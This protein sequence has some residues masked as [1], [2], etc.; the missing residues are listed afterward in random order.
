MTPNSTELEIEQLRK[1]IEQHNRAYYLDNAP[2]ISDADY[3][4]LMQ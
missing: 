3:D 4:A 2:T 1:T